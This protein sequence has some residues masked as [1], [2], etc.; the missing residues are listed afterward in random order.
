MSSLDKYRFTGSDKFSIKDFDTSDTGEFNDREEAV[1]EFVKNLRAINKLQ[2]KLYAERKEGVIFIFQ[3]MDAA[4]KDGVIRTVFS[5]LSPHG[6][7]EFCFKVPSSEEASHDYLWR[8]WSALPPRGNISI[9]NRSYYEDV[10]VGRVHKL[11]ENQ[12]RPDRLRKVDIIHQRYGQIKDFERYLFNTGT[13][14][15]KVFL[16]VSK[17]EQARRFISRIDTPKK[18][19][20]VS[21]GDIAERE[22]WDE[23]MEAFE[24]MV[25][26]TSTKNSPWYVVPSDHKWYSRLI[27]SRIV[28]HTLKDMN[29][30]YPVIE[31]DELEAAKQFRQKLAESIE[32]YT[33]E[34]DGE[35]E[36]FSKT[37]DIAADI[38]LDEEMQKIGEKKEMLKDNGFRAV[39][40]LLARGC[41]LKSTDEIV[42]AVAGADYEEA[43][44]TD[45]TDEDGL[46]GEEEPA[47][48][49][50][51][52]HE[53]ALEAARERFGLIPAVKLSDKEKALIEAIESLRMA[54]E[55]AD[56]YSVCNIMDVRPSKLD[57]IVSDAVVKGI[58][59]IGED[60]FLCVTDVGYKSLCT[61]K[62][63]RKEEKK[64]MR[65]LEC[66]STQELK[67]FM[68]LCD[69]FTV[70]GEDEQ[71]EECPETCGD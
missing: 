14:V 4:G 1:D 12:S 15:V 41:I 57:K 33:E 71:P 45:I 5:T 61:G 47:V 32:N 38:L 8:F 13:R 50:G 65:F 24:A 18:N 67:D 54:D 19:W 68:E 42:S 52:E 16:N 60:S 51:P 39:Q 64:F 35:A 3:A 7:K 40:E 53:A 29:P 17:D 34:E 70:N 31:S 36:E 48:E 9:F 21:S 20:K 26:T 58:A 46:P 59:D 66:L 43:A 25:N 2:Q 63:D 10:L 62:K 23:Y 44:D 28:L 56:F 37:G 11:Y 6:V 22:Y 55:N 27:V 69:D 49:D 30:E